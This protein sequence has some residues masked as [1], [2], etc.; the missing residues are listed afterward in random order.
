MCSDSDKAEG[1]EGPEPSDLP[2]WAFINLQS[3]FPSVADR[4]GGGLLTLD[5]GGWALT[6]IGRGLGEETRLSLNAYLDPIAHLPALED[7]LRE[8][9]DT[10]QLNQSLRRRV[11]AQIRA[12]LPPRGPAPPTVR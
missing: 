7:Q 6:V 2:N 9:H 10:L 1:H 11:L 5:P 4:I 12:E 8:I 3:L